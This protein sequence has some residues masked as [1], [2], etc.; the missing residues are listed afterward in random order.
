MAVASWRPA[1]WVQSAFNADP[2]DP[3]VIP[4]WSDLS[5]P[6]FIGADN[7]QRGRQYELDQ[8]QASQ[9]S[10]SFLDQSEYLNPDNASSPYAPN[11]LPL[12]QILFQAMWPNQAT[13][14]L[15][16]ANQPASSILGTTVD[17]Y[18]PSFESYSA[19]STVPW[20]IPVGG[21]APVVGTTTPHSGSK[22]LTYTVAS[23]S[24]EQGVA[25]TVPAVPGRQY[26]ASAYMRQSDNSIQVIGVGGITDA[27][28]TFDRTASNGWGTTS[29]PDIGG[30]WTTTGGSSS[31]YSVLPG[32]ANIEGTTVNVVRTVTV[33][34]AN[35]DCDVIGYVQVDQ[36]A[37][38]AAIRAG[39]VGRRTASNTM[40]FASADFNTDNTVT[41]AVR[42][43]N[44]GSETTLTSVTMPFLYQ[45]DTLYGLRLTVA[46][47][48]LSAS[49]WP[50]ASTIPTTYTLTTTDGSINGAGSVGCYQ[51]LVTSNTNTNPNTT[52][53]FV[54]AVAT[55]AGSSTTTANSYVRLTVT[56]TA[57]ATSHT[58]QVASLAPAA[59][60]VLIDDIQYEQGASA[61]TFT[62]SGPTIYGVFRGF[63]ERWPSQ[64]QNG[65]FLGYCSAT[66]VDAFEPLN[67]YTLGPEYYQQVLALGPVLYWPL[68]DSSGST[69]F[70]EASGNNALPLVNYPSPK[71]GGT[72]PSA[73]E[74]L[75]ISGDPDATGVTFAA[76]TALNSRGTII[77]CGQIVNHGNGFKFP[78]VTGGP[79][80]ASAAAWVIAQ[81]PLVGAPDAQ[82]IVW[83]VLPGSGANLSTSVSLSIGSDN[84][85]SVAFGGATS[86]DIAGAGSVITDGLPHLLVGTVTQGATSTTGVAYVDGVQVDSVTDTTAS[87]G[88]LLTTAATSLMVGGFFAYTAFQQIVNGTVGHVAMWNRALSAA[89]VTALWDAGGLG[90]A[91]ETSGARVARYVASAW[92]G[93]TD[94]DTGSSVMGISTVSTGTPVLQACQD[95]TTSEQGNFWADRD[96]QIVFAGR[97]D[98]YLNLTSLWTFGEDEAGGELPYQDDLEYD[99]DPTF[100]Y[101]T[102]QV[103]NADGVTA[104]VS[105]LPS[106]RSYF[107]R[108]NTTAADLQSDDDAIQL[109]YWLLNTHDQPVQRIQSITLDPM[110]NPDLWPVILSLEIGDRVTVKRRP[111]AANGGAGLTMTGDFFVENIAHN[112]IDMSAQTTWK[113]TLLLS[114]AVETSGVFIFDNATY[115]TFDGTLSRFAY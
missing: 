109:G 33:G 2:N 85:I 77:G 75:N 100:V 76:Q 52:W 92:N 16:N 82:V 108:S 112:G 91:G 6:F 14:N 4:S 87:L 83:P 56:F 94:I 45:I 90:N 79:W 22:D 51:K 80:A 105:N 101:G 93:L 62:T 99:F 113:T 115:G 78:Q 98:R 74:P 81:P 28:D 70:G 25:W 89:E 35:S 69:A 27:Q 8:N 41:L 107:P 17:G 68:N 88:G 30:A 38:G 47:N 86:F 11:V 104:T 102:V 61:T 19:A 31:D 55:V 3:S 29:S 63:V 23:S 7:L 42:K 114:P 60:T 46:G 106:Q 9:P 66:A 59:S 21:T 18:D 36:V 50:A 40:Y 72:A 95:V 71:G 13:G 64:W 84:K 53:T 110:G 32:L 39:V 24:V 57:T 1:L 58:I 44:G 37:T 34:S 12:R 49:L 26:T 67:L 54:Q 103:D 96:G 97:Q 65:G 111:K 15:M 10:F 73:G 43:L 5:S 48:A 20:I